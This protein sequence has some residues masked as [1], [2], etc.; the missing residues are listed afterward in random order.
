[1]RSS[2]Q[3]LDAACAERLVQVLLP[4]M[5]QLCVETEA[6]GMQGLTLSQFRLLTPLMQRPY[7]AGELAA[8]LGVA[9]ST[10]SGLIAPLARR[11][12]VERSQGAADRRVVALR[13]TE[14]G[15]ACY[16]LMQ[17]HVLDFLLGLFGRIPGDTKQA[18]LLGLT[19]LDEAIARTRLTD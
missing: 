13:P 1:M 3:E 12:L 8:H 14:H 2:A 4:L 10:L 9:A 19:G 18:L 5:R 6:S 17:Q 15:R 16:A 11:G 7:T